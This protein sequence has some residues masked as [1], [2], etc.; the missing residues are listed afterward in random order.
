MY[1]HGNETD[2]C[3]IESIF[4]GN[5]WSAKGVFQDIMT[6]LVVVGGGG[7]GGYFFL[8]LNVTHSHQT[9]PGISFSHNF[10]VNLCQV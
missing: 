8:K 9:I 5:D 10:T 1:L 3:V 6:F 7:G 4:S 2:V